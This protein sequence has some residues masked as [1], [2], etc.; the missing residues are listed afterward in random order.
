MKIISSKTHDD[1]IQKIESLTQ[2]LIA[3]RAQRGELI[4]FIGTL[5]Y[6]TTSAIRKEESKVR[7]REK[8]VFSLKEQGHVL[9]EL[10]N[11]LLDKEWE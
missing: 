11:R 4:D 8:M 9:A 5:R 3:E 7:P 6:K 10:Q 2:E 1:L